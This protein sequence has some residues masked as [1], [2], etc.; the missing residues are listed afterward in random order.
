MN[1]TIYTRQ[2]CPLCLDG[3]AVASSVFGEESITLVDIDLDLMLMEKYTNRVPVLESEGGEAIA[4][5]IITE[6]ELE[7]F[8]NSSAR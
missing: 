2:N 1:V 6:S 8:I 4:E 5:G 7:G 3:I